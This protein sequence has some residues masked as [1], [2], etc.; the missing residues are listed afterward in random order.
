VFSAA[1]FYR[2]TGMVSIQLGVAPDRGR[3]ALGRVRQELEML[4]RD[5]P[6]EEEVAAARFQLK[7]S[8]VMGQESVSSRMVHLAHEELYRGTYMSPDEQLEHIL[9]VTREQVVEMAR[10][11]LPPGRFALSAI[12]PTSGDRLDERDWPVET[13]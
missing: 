10:R 9:A 11:L 12:G 6:P 8:V 4:V 7:G 2:E 13:N 1:D 5:G 3:E